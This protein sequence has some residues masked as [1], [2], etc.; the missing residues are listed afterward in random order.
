MSRRK[1]GWR[2]ATTLVL[3]FSVA[4]CGKATRTPIV[5]VSGTIAYE[6]GT[7]LPEGTKILFSPVL[8]G[9]GSAMAESDA[10]GHFDVEHASGRSGAEIGDYLVE[11]RSPAGLEQEFYRSVPSGYTDGGALLTT[12][13]DEGDAI[14]LVLKKGRRKRS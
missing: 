6:D 2:L 13:S 1:V 11:L 9:A 8:G 14:Q 5:L 12:V 3:A 4:G 10:D 7:K